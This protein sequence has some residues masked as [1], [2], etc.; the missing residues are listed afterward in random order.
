MLHI[1]AVCGLGMG[2]SLIMK[3]TIQSALDSLGVDAKVEHWDAGT[4][5]SKD[6]D[7]IVTTNQ[8]RNKLGDL[9][10][11][12]FVDNIIDEDEVKE[13]LKEKLNI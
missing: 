2:S 3:M 9:D 5:K 6:A 7:I 11:V 12:I 10:N 8:F 13:K 4:V 1:V